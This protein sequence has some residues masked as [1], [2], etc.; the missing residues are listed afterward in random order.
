M[1]NNLSIW[2]KKTNL[3]NLLGELLSPN[4]ILERYP[5]AN[6]EKVLIETNPDGVLIAI[7]DFYIIRKIYKIPESLGDID[8]INAIISAKEENE[9]IASNPI[10]YVSADTIVEIITGGGE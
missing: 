6:S 1:N 4:Q 10:E 8:A 9:K 3:T 5:A 2:D 7:D